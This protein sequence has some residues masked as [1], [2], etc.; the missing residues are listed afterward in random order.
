VLLPPGARENV[1]I[2]EA[3]LAELPTCI[4]IAAPGSGV[5]TFA[6]E[7]GTLY[8]VTQQ[9][10][11]ALRAS[12]AGPHEEEFSFDFSVSPVVLLIFGLPV[13]AGSIAAFV[14]TMKFFMD[15]PKKPAT[16]WS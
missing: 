7:R 6:P 8:T 12:A 11:G 16:G 1:I 10:G 13:L 4:A 2:V 3:G 14:I 15:W 9:Q 5:V